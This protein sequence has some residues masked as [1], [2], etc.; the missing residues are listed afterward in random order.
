MVRIAMSLLLFFLSMPA[1]SQQPSHDC[2]VPPEISKWLESH[3]PKWRVKSEEDLEAYHQKLWR[4]N[5]PNACPGIAEGHFVAL[6][7][8]ALA[9]LLVPSI[10]SNTGYKV[11]VLAK[12]R[13]KPYSAASVI[14]DGKGE[15]SGRVVIYRAP[16]GVYEAV[17]STRRVQI[18]LDGIV[19]EAMEAGATLYFWRTGHFEHIIISE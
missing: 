10:P 6:G 7:E 13:G 15:I 8:K 16:P 12:P 4:E 9:L 14:D 1:W 17:E 2:A 5:R 18:K 3:F 11:V 19:V